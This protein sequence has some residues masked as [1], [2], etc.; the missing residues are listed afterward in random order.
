M[1]DARG[2]WI[3][4]GD[5]QVLCWQ[6][7]GEFITDKALRTWVFRNVDGVMRYVDVIRQCQVDAYANRHRETSAPQ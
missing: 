6:I 7:D 3:G 2:F 5:K 4:R 1:A